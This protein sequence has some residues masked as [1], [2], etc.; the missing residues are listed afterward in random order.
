MYLLYVGDGRC[1]VTNITSNNFL[2]GDKIVDG[3]NHIFTSNG[4]MKIGGNW[5]EVD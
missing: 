2:F 4:A 1:V 5:A 3:K